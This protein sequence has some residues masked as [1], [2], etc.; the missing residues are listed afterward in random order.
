MSQIFFVFLGGFAPLRE[1]YF[2]RSL[3]LKEDADE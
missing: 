2:L 1:V 3:F